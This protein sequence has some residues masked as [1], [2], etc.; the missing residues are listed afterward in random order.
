MCNALAEPRPPPQNARRIL[1]D[2]KEK[3][4]NPVEKR[5]RLE[6][7]IDPGV[8]HGREGQGVGSGGVEVGAHLHRDP[9]DPG[10][11][12]S[13]LPC[14]CGPAGQL[15]CSYPHPHPQP[16]GGEEQALEGR[17]QPEATGWKP[18]PSRCCPAAARTFQDFRVTLQRPQT[19]HSPPTAAWAQTFQTALQTSSLPS[20]GT[21]L[22]HPGQLSDQAW[23]LPPFL[24]GPQHSEPCTH[25]SAKAPQQPPPKAGASDEL[26]AAGPW[27]PRARAEPSRK[28]AAAGSERATHSSLQPGTPSPQSHSSPSSGTPLPPSHLALEHMGPHL[29]SQREMWPGGPTLRGL[30]AGPA[31]A[32]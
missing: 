18:H 11:P 3:T 7:A 29:G 6:G 28:E 1:A 17:A 10:R 12:R 13:P 23:P 26:G 25:P 21:S 20:P 30:Q 19:V 24:S 5:A 22:F 16:L 4:D 15:Q 32:P 9:G 8:S 27:T 14:S 2:Q 31:P